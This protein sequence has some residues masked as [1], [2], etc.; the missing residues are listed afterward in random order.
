MTL[1]AQVHGF[2]S[3][4]VPTGR[5]TFRKDN[6]VLGSATLDGTGTATF[7]LPAGRL[8]PGQYFVSGFYEGDARFAGDGGADLLVLTR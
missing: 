4:A 6:I 7:T 1:T 2:T 3:S 8:P 5:V